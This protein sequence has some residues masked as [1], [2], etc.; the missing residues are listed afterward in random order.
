[1]IFVTSDTHFG[2][3]NII[4]YCNRPFI[5]S[6]NMNEILIKNWNSV[7]SPNDTTFVLGDFSVKASKNYLSQLNGKKVLVLGNHDKK[8]KLEDGWEK[9]H[10]I[11]EYKHNGKYVI[12]NHYPMISWNGSSHGSY[13]LYGHMHGT[14]SIKIKNSLDVGVDSHNYY[15]ISLDNVFDILNDD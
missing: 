3:D 15:P 5:N 6:E 11:Y 10:Q 9:I 8:P 4:K 14:C 12:M 13:H 1:M 7:V 2:H